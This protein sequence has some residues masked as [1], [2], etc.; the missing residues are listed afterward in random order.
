MGNASV[1]V[2]QLDLSGKRAQQQIRIQM[3]A[4]SHAHC[5]DH[6]L[7]YWQVNQPQV[8]HR[9]HTEAPCIVS[10]FLSFLLTYLLADFMTD[11]MTH[12]PTDLQPHSNGGVDVGPHHLSI[13]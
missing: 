1:M 8:S 9:T 10:L 4:R 2:D 6:A 13:V 12:I 11:F 7:G 3:H 5:H